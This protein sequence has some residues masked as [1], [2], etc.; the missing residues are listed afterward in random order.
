MSKRQI[1]RGQWIEFVRI[2]MKSVDTEE[3]LSRFVISKRSA[4]T[5]LKRAGGRKTCRPD[6]QELNQIKHPLDTL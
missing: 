3:I 5:N 6:N 2:C 4:W 1:E